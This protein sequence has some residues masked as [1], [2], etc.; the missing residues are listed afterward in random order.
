MTIH[1]PVEGG[2][3]D[4]KWTQTTG[5]RLN[6]TGDVTVLDNLGFF[7]NSGPWTLTQGFNC[8]GSGEPFEPFQGFIQCL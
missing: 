6:R 1:G 2:S 3:T 4:D 5:N 7:I 8:F